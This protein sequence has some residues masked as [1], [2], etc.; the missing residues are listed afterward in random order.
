MKGMDALRSCGTFERQQDEIDAEVI[1]MID[2]RVEEGGDLR[3]P[4]LV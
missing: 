4:A 3:A 2:N 1:R